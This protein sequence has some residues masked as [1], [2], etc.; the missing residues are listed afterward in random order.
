MTS[1][2]P[3][4]YTSLTDVTP[5]GKADWVFEADSNGKVLEIYYSG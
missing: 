3:E 1:G 2:Q 4:N 5:Y